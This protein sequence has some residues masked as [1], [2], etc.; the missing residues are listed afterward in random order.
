LLENA[1][2]ADPALDK[3]RLKVLCFL[4]PR[5]STRG[6]RE[7]IDQ[8]LGGDPA[9]AAKARTILR[10]TLGEIML[11]SGEDGSLWAEY[12]IQPAAL[13]QGAGTCG[14]GEAICLVPALPVRV[15]VR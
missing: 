11:S 14:R 5:L 12:G 3:R 7:Q 10:D 9:A 4:S 13:L 15:R 1:P 2:G 8:G 6:Y